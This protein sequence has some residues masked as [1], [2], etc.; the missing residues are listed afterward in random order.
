MYLSIL[1]TIGSVI[2]LLILSWV[3]S[4]LQKAKADEEARKEAELEAQA[5][6]QAITDEYEIEARHEARLQ[7]ILDDSLSDDDAG[8]ML[9]Q[10]PGDD[11]IPGPTNPKN[12]NSGSSP[13]S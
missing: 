6:K 13:V 8:R 1:G 4:T 9:S 2:A 3:K 5:A 11:E 12:G 10:S 7:K